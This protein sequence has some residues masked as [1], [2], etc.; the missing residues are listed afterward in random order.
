MPCLRQ[1]LPRGCLPG[2]VFIGDVCLRG[3]HIP[4]T[5]R[6]MPPVDAIT[7]RCK[8]I[9]FPQLLLRTVMKQVYTTEPR[10]SPPDSDVTTEPDDQYPNREL[11]TEPRTSP[12]DSDV[13]TEPDDQYPGRGLTTEPNVKNIVIGVVVSVVILIIICVGVVYVYWRCKVRSL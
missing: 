1:G 3:V 4:Q 10:T 5:Q 7:D 13:M 6:Q 11:T 9:T 12:P 2:G 8:T